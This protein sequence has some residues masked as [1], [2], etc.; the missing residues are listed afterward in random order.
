[1]INIFLM[2]TYLPTK[3]L[4]NYDHWLIFSLYALLSFLLISPYSSVP[5]STYY[6]EVL[7][8]RQLE[9]YWNPF[10]PKILLTSLP[11]PWSWAE[12]WVACLLLMKISAWSHKTPLKSKYMVTTWPRKGNKRAQCLVLND[13]VI[14]KD[15]LPL[16]ANE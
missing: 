15:T 4:S 6:T 14:L 1:M 9:Q 7:W 12:S 16:K 11:L 2:P 10:L 3:L 5:I 8:A 13:E